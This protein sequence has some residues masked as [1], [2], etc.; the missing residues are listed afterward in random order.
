MVI[1]LN[2]AATI[3]EPEPKTTA[4]NAVVSIYDTHKA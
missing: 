3:P 1:P 4:R 2:E